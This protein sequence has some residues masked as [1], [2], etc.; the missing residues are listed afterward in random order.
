GRNSAPTCGTPP[1]SGRRAATSP[2]CGRPPAGDSPSTQRLDC[3]GGGGRL[4][5]EALHEQPQRQHHPLHGQRYTA[6]DFGALA[7][8]TLVADAAV[9]AGGTEWRPRRAAGRGLD[10]RA[11]LAYMREVLAAL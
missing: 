8:R 3:C 2:G 11:A 6:N 7:S 5:P 9:A 1:A 4:D 10:D